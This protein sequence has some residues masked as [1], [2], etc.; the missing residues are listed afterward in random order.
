MLYSLASRFAQP[1]LMISPLACGHV[2]VK[3]SGSLEF[4]LFLSLFSFSSSHL[5][6]LFPFA[7]S[8]PFAFLHFLVFSFLLFLAFSCLHFLAILILPFLGPPLLHSQ[9][10]AKVRLT[11]PDPSYVFSKG[12]ATPL[13]IFLVRWTFLVQGALPVAIVLDWLVVTVQQAL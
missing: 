13:E 2:A 10:F 3:L 7:F 9:E 5:S 6:F 11:H 1:N 4:V 8:V 12:F